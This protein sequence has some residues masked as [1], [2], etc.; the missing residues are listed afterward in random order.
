MS[1]GGAG[2]FAIPYFIFIGLT[3]QEA[4]ATGKMGGL[5]AATGAVTAFRGKGLVHRRFIVPF[6]VITT[7]CALFSAWLMPRLDASLFQ[8]IIGV[9]L[10]LLAPT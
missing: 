10:L 9:T 4:V 5:G 7:I 1:G 8:S 2:F 6:L 3:P